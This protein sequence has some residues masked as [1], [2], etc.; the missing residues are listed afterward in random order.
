MKYTV[1]PHC[2]QANYN[3]LLESNMIKVKMYTEGK[4][5]EY[6]FKIHRFYN[7]VNKEFIS[8]G[9]QHSLYKNTKYEVC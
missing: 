8:S 3:L 4:E 9:L 6:D 1:K 2:L 5:K 7:H